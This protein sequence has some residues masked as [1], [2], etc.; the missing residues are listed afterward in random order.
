MKKIFVLCLIALVFSNCKRK[1]QEIEP[2]GTLMKYPAHCYN[3]IADS[4]EIS[5]DCGGECGAC[6][7]A[8]P[9]C[10]QT[11]NTVTFNSMNYSVTALTCSVNSGSYYD[12]TGNVMGGTILIRVFGTKPDMSKSHM[13]V[14]NT[15]PSGGEA[16]IELHTG[17][18]GN[19]TGGTGQVFINAVNGK[20]VA[21][22]CNVSFY[23]YVTLNTYN[24]NRISLSCQ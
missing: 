2:D 5:I 14:S 16:H 4:T 21:Y 7:M 24:A 22:A 9:T 18:L 15:Y 10:T 3:A 8:V 1:L 23:S 19:M 12:F 6:D 17:S 13:L 11:P 20:Y